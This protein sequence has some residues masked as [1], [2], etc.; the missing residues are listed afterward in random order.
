MTAPS[1]VARFAG[2]VTSPPDPRVL[3]RRGY[4][5]ADLADLVAV[6]D[7]CGDWI[8]PAEPR[9]WDGDSDRGATVVHVPECPGGDA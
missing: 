6:C 3:W 1:P 2:T 5:Y 8:S 9:E 4:D 7:R